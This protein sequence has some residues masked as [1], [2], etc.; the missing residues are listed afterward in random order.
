MGTSMKGNVLV[1]V[2]VATCLLLSG[3][4]GGKTEITSQEEEKLL[5]G[6][7]GSKTEVTSQEEGKVYWNLSLDE[8]KAIYASYATARNEIPYSLSAE[9][10]KLVRG[11]R[12]SVC[13]SHGISDTTLAFIESDAYRNDW[14]P[15][16]SE[17]PSYTANAERSNSSGR[18]GPSNAL[19]NAHRR[20]IFYELVALQDQIPLLAY[21]YAER[22]EDAKSEIARKHGISMAQL[23]S[24]IHEGA[25]NNWD[26]PHP[27]N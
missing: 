3:C 6:G 23:N 4:G 13:L 22:N 2:I 5:S 10:A 7:D 18:P 1:T 17:S 11:L 12:R 20:A 15:L 25:T 14:L 21:D 24:L 8:K 16:D 19:S 9:Y 26:M 27:P